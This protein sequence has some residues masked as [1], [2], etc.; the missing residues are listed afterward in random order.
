MKKTLI[1]SI[2]LIFL[3]ALPATG[4][5]AAEVEAAAENLCGEDLT[6]TLEGGTLYIT[7]SGPMDDGCP[8]YDYRE[9]I[10]EVVLSGNVT[11]VGAEAFADLTH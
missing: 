9:D 7:G 8:W 11:T 3:A 6:W 10:T 1:L 5:M 2:L 4:A